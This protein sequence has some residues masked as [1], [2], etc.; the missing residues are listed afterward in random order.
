MPAE[1]SLSPFAAPEVKKE[2]AARRARNL[3]RIVDKITAD[4]LK[5]FAGLGKEVG[6]PGYNPDADKTW[7]DRTGRSEFG[8]IV[9]REVMKTRRDETQ[10]KADL[11]ILLLKTRL[12]EDAWEKQAQ[13]VEQDSRNARAIDVDAKETAE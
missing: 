1:K 7:A 10:I 4:G 2:H 3:V 8:A 12:D 11:G 5:H 6:E 13:K 9:Y